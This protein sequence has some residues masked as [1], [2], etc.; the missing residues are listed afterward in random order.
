MVLSTDKNWCVY[1]HT[2]RLDGRVYIG[3]T[4]NIKARWKPS[5]YKNC[6]NFY[7]AIQ[8]YGWENFDHE[9][10]YNNLTLDEANELEEKTIIEYDSINKGFNLSSGGLNHFV[11]PQ[12]KLKMSET[13]KGVA[14]TEAHKRAISAALK[15]YERTA[16]H[17]RNNQLA[18]HRKEVMCI[19][20][21]I[22]YESLSEAE[23]LTGVLGESI[24]RQCRGKQ[25]TAGG[26]HWRF[27]NNEDSK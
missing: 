12:T 17:N 14:K 10:L 4:N 21:G 20:T 7:A 19:E 6:I 2:L 23:R 24:S 11:S 22:V 9:I 16:E 26:L 27:I 5:A 18:Q 25:K 1:K 13:R 8:K 3:Q 15:Q